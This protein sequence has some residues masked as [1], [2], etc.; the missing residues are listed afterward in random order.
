MEICRYLAQTP[1]ELA[2]CP[3]PEGFS[4]AWMACHFSPYGTALTNLPEFLPPG[5]LLILNDRTPIR[6]HDPGRIREQLLQTV[7]ELGCAGV[8]LDFQRPG[9]PETEALCRAL[10]GFPCPL[11]VSE[12]YG[13]ALD[14][15]VFPDPC[16]P[17]VPVEEYL[18]PWRGREIWLDMAPEALELRLTEAGCEPIVLPWEPVPEDAFAEEGLCCRYRIT[19]EETA[20]RFTL[21]RDAQALEGLLSSARSLGVTKAIGLYQEWKYFQ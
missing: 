19:L 1:L 14:G 16:P 5:S 15:P 9:E 2:N 18:A 11:G 12:A 17:D 20:I 4:P 7:E 21:W 10:S 6:G 8:L 3:L 13:E